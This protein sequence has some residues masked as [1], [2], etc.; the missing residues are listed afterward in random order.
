ME[1]SAG[2]SLAQKNVIGPCAFCVLDCSEGSREVSAAASVWGG[3]EHTRHL[4]ESTGARAGH[5]G[6]P[7]G[8][9]RG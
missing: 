8:G 9:Q 5:R 2:M 1:I 6:V 3:E 4:V 7:R